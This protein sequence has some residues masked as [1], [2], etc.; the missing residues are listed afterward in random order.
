MF[1]MTRCSLIRGVHYERFHCSQFVLF[2]LKMLC[3]MLQ[4]LQC[5]HSNEKSL[6]VG[7]TRTMMGNAVDVALSCGSC[8]RELSRLFTL[9]RMATNSNPSLSTTMQC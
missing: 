6:C 3:E 4:P 1:T 5:P 9:Q 2:D 8:G 7:T